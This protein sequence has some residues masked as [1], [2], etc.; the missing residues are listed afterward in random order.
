MEGGNYMKKISKDRL[1]FLTVSYILISILAVICLLPFVLVISGSFSSQEAILKYGYS[2]FPREF[3]LQAYKAA[4]LMPTDL[5]R[6]YGVTILTT[7]TG[8]TLGL[9]ITAMT[10]YVLS[11]K[12]FEWRSKF[13]F[14]FYF[15]TLFSGGLVPWYILCVRY[16]KLGDSFIA[17]VVPMMLNVFYL[18]VM[19]SFMASI[20]EAI[21]ESGK[22]D[23]ANDFTIFI[24]LIL[25]LAKPALASIGL[26]IALGYWNDW[27]L[28][29]IFIQNQK[30]FTLQFY[31]F[32]IVTGA[33]A[34]QNLSGIPGIENIRIPT[35]TLKLAMTVITI[36]PI[37]LLY[38]AL[39]KYF[40]KGLTIGSVKG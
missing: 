18:L 3:S 28:S 16:L 10:G 38:P 37:F 32:R 36:G 26:F 11:R 13:A 6:A 29:F 22:I 19:K 21:Y 15:T 4:F 25:P 34:L 14:F 33:Q 24:R 23:G 39:Q 20:P 31:L 30:L 7:I 8:T 2:L 27:Y 40:V 17:L 9:F 5:L 1:L 12:D 35:E